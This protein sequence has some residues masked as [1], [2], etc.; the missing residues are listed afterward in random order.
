MQH[1][2]SASGERDSVPETGWETM[3]E[4]PSAAPRPVV[5]RVATG[6]A[7]LD[8]VLRGGF[9]RGASYLILGEPG[10][11]KTTLANHLAFNHGASGG[12]ALYVTVLAEAHD[13]MIMH[14][15]GFDFFLRERV[16]Q[17]VHYFS[18][19]DDVRQHGLDAGL[20]SIRRLVHDYG[21]TLLVIDGA[22]R[23]ED[24]AASRIDYRR[25]NAELHAQLSLLGCTALL[26]SQ[27]GTDNEALH[28]IGTHVDGIMSLEDRPLGA[29]DIRFLRILK[30]R[31]GSTLRGYHEFAITSEGVEVYPRLESVLEPL[32][33]RRRSRQKR[34]LFGVDGLDD[35]L[36]GGLLTG[37]T[38][39]VIGPPGI[40]KTTAGLHFI[41]DGAHRGEPGLIASFSGRRPSNSSR[42][43]IRWGWISGGQVEAGRVPAAL[44]AVAESPRSINGWASCSPLSPSTSPSGC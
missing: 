19:F 2:R 16:G 36:L 38:T 26:L 28:T 35:M 37:T 43:P 11:G 32:R 40:G 27:P 12:V 7:G 10:T 24:F 3:A 17:T 31:G 5:E 8:E 14:I 34:H 30:Q 18:L 44:G 33:A 42:R 25:F 23:L 4:E 41:A 29:R 15:G 20:A 22:A 39:L 9:V 21:A 6:I 13:R 1:G